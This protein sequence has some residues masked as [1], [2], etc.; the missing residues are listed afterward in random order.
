MKISGIKWYWVVLF[1]LLALIVVLAF[2]EF[3]QI[4]LPTHS[5][6]Q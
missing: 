5:P 2:V 1:F 6:R 4:P 3:S